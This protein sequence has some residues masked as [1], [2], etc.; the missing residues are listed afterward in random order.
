MKTI[1]EALNELKTFSEFVVTL[2]YAAIL[3][4][5]VDLAI[6]AQYV[7]DKIR[8]LSYDIRVATIYAVRS[9]RSDKKEITQLA[10]L[11]QVGVAAK[12]ISDGIDDLVEIVIRG[13]GAHP[14]LRTIYGNSETLTKFQIG[15]NSKLLGKTL[16]AV[17]DMNIK[18]LFIRR[19]KDYIIS[20]DIY[21]TPLKE[22]DVI[23]VKSSEEENEKVRE[24]FE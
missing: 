20:D 1:K 5:D 9:S 13:G 8:S 21:I 18:I 4:N 6:E 10:S 17:K 12:E 7:K 23:V 14:V 2:G 24:I 3:Q 15:K 22:N 16:K 19:E 11:L